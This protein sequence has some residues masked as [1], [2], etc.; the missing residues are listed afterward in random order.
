MDRDKFIL[1]L[2]V[3]LEKRGVPSAVYE[4]SRFVID[5]PGIEGETTPQSAAEEWVAGAADSDVPDPARY[6]AS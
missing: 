2:A 1:V 4:A 3:L 6:G 5:N